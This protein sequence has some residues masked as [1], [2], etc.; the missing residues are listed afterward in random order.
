M[1][2]F[3]KNMNEK[4]RR[5]GSYNNRQYIWN[6]SKKENIRKTRNQ[7]S[8]SG[9]GNS[10]YFFWVYQFDLT[11]IWLEIDICQRKIWNKMSVWFFSLHQNWNDLNK[12]FMKAQPGRVHSS[13]R[14]LRKTFCSVYVFF[15]LKKMLWTFQTTKCV[16]MI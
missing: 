6:I 10:S 16:I 11:F 4:L 1:S 15:S 12:L 7:S 9:H 14:I 2:D 13:G 8:N 5:A 3:K